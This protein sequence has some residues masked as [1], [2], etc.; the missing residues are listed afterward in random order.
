[1]IVFADEHNTL[2]KNY[3]EAFAKRM[4]FFRHGSQEKDMLLRLQEETPKVHPERAAKALS[5][6]D[7]RSSL[8]HMYDNELEDPYLGLLSGNEPA[9]EHIE[10]DGHKMLPSKLKT[11]CYDGLKNDLDED[12]I[13]KLKSDP[14]ETLKGLSPHVRI[15]VIKHINHG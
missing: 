4:Q 7:E 14:I 8:N 13:G 5:I 10:F 3:N 11:C 15:I 1:M 6:F 2:R 9:E 12:L